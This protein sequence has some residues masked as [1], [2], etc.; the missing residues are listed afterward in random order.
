MLTSFACL[1]SNTHISE[2]PVLSSERL[3]T[4]VQ[5]FVY[6]SF[7]RFNFIVNNMIHI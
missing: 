6:T 5:M 1:I 4:K 2:A 7:A 3:M